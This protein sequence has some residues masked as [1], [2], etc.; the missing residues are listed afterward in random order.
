ME[1]KITV[2]QE[3]FERVGKQNVIRVEMGDL[4]REMIIYP[5]TNI[6]STI[7]R[8]T[9][10]IRYEKIERIITRVISFIQEKVEI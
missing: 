4:Y 1:R 7:K 10:S 5:D 3:D 6:E 8:M 2:F 9:K